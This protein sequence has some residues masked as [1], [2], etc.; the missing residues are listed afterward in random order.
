MTT[1]HQRTAQKGYRH[2]AMARRLLA[3]RGALIETAYNAVRFVPIEGQPGKL[4]PMSTRHDLYGVWDAVCVEIRQKESKTSVVISELVRM[5]YF[6][7]VTS[8]GN[9]SARRKKIHASAFPCTPE[10]MLLGYRGRG[11]FRVLRGPRFDGEGEDVKVPPP[12]KK[13]KRETARAAG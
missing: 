6:V 12:V 13:A 8:A 5:T 3:A 11:I 7:Q 4:R 9:I 1:A 2:M 10:D